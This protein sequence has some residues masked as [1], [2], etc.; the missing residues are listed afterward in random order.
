[1]A[2]F[3]STINTCQYQCMYN[4]YVHIYTCILLIIWWALLIRKEYWKKKVFWIALSFSFFLCGL[5][6]QRNK[7][8]EMKM[9]G[10]LDMFA[11]KNCFIFV[12]LKIKFLTTMYSLWTIILW[13]HLP[14][15]YQTVVHHMLTLSLV[16]FPLIVSM[17]EFC[18]H[19]TSSMLYAKKAARNDRYTS[20]H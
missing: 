20:R 7:M 17:L 4:I 19:E 5:F 13:D 14:I 16:E 9:I 3:Y 1:M 18:E 15:S 11:F 6:I 2:C 10:I 8:N 12:T